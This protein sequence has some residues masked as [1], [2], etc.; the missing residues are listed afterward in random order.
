M[1][2]ASAMSRN[3]SL[4]CSRTSDCRLAGDR[5]KRWNLL[6]ATTCMDR[7]LNLVAGR[8]FPCRITILSVPSGGLVSGLRALQMVTGVLAI[9]CSRL[10]S[11]SAGRNV[12]VLPVATISNRFGTILS[13]V[14]SIWS[15]GGLCRT[16]S[17]DWFV[18]VGTGNQLTSPRS[19]FGVVWMDSFRQDNGYLMRSPS[20]S[21]SFSHMEDVPCNAETN[22]G[23]RSAHWPDLAGFARC[24][25]P[26][27]WGS[28]SILKLCGH[29]LLPFP[30][31]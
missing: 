31:F 10:L 1:C 11:T 27:D 6:L 3:R 28:I 17:A 26:D 2:L 7:A 14:H 22:A 4:D 24:C 8:R 30:Y 23:C 21:R 13:F 25:S 12:A 5:C 20:A 19:R 18:Q 29:S 16:R 15:S 9:K